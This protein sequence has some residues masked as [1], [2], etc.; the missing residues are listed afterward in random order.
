MILGVRMVSR[1]QGLRQKRG[2]P[3]PPGKPGLEP[4]RP[5]WPTPMPAQLRWLH[6]RIEQVRF[7]RAEVLLYW[8]KAVRKA[9]D[10]EVAGL[11]ADTALDSAYDAVRLGCVAI[12]AAHHIRPKGRQGG[13]HETTFGAVAALGLEGCGN[14][15]ADSSE[16]RAA[17][18]E[19]DYSPNSASDDD[20]QVAVRWMH[21]TLPVLRAA[22]ISLDPEMASFLPSPP[23]RT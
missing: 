15:V 20:V 19:T 16:V 11:S 21:E 12:L 4:G 6:D 17:R 2:E 18:H 3:E 5:G 22:L 1:K 8:Q 14:L 9:R 23:T 10:A 13:H 7:S